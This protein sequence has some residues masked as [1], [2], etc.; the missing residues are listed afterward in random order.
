ML[1]T[2]DLLSLGRRCGLNRQR[3]NTSLSDNVSVGDFFGGFLSALFD[4]LYKLDSQLRFVVKMIPVGLLDA[5]GFSVALFY[6]LFSYLHLPRLMFLISS[7][8]KG[9]S[10]IG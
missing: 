6:I 8:R 3:I 7:S 5:V 4:T 1:V 9:T 10:C 2:G